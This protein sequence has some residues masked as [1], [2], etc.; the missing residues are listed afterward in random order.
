MTGTDQETKCEEGFEV[1]STV[2]DEEEMQGEEMKQNPE[3][4]TG[5][6]KDT[7]EETPAE[8]HPSEEAE[9]TSL[10][11]G[12]ENKMEEKSSENGEDAAAD[13]VE[14]TDEAGREAKSGE[15]DEPLTSAPNARAENETRA[16]EDGDGEA[17]GVKVET[18][19]ELSDERE[20]LSRE[21]APVAEAEEGPGEGVWEE[22]GGTAAETGGEAGGD[23]PSAERDD[24]EDGADE[25]VQT[26]DGEEEKP[27]EKDEEKQSDGNEMGDKGEER[28]GEDNETKTDSG[29]GGNENQQNDAAEGETDQSQKTNEG[30]DSQWVKDGNEDE[31]K[32][33]TDVGEKTSEM[34]GEVARTEADESRAE[35]PE[36]GEDSSGKCEKEE[37]GGIVSEELGKNTDADSAK[38]MKNPEGRSVEPKDEAANTE[39]QE[40][41][42]EAPGEEK[43]NG[44]IDAENGEISSR[45]ESV[46]QKDAEEAETE[47]QGG[48]QTAKNTRDERKTDEVTE[49]ERA[50]ATDLTAEPGDGTKRHTAEQMDPTPHAGSAKSDAKDEESNEDGPETE[51][52]EAKSCNFPEEVGEILIKEVRTEVTSEQASAAVPPSSSA[53]TFDIFVDT[54]ALEDRSLSAVADLAAARGESGETQASKASEDGTSVVLN[55]RA[56]FPDREER[57]AVH[58]EITEIVDAGENVDLVSN[59]VTTHQVAKFFETFVE[60]LDDLKDTLDEESQRDRY[61]EPL[62][63]EKTVD[64]GGREQTKEEASEGEHEGNVSKTS[65]ACENDQS[66]DKDQ[67]QEETEV[68]DLMLEDEPSDKELTKELPARSEGSR[69][70]L[71]NDEGREGSVQMNTEQDRVST[72]EVKDTPESHRPISRGSPEHQPEQDHP[73]L[74]D[75]PT[76]VLEFRAPSE[77]DQHSQHSTQPGEP[78]KL[79][80]NQPVKAEE[81]WG[82]SERVMEAPVMWERTPEEPVES[83]PEPRDTSASRETTDLQLIP[84]LLHSKD[85]LSVSSLQDTHFPHSSYPMLAAARTQNGQ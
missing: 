49:E 81:T 51:T 23:A 6:S 77:A 82:A 85:R 68:M 34:C 80:G 76:P 37:E 38:D 55:P 32:E 5:D 9:N 22:S 13:D 21:E 47:A 33:A 26:R 60:P 59:W 73:D 70:P 17:G 62:R 20:A 8:N 7:A 75:K 10:P 1:Q 31:E 48:V 57:P 39:G 30:E 41:A 18:K 28:R 35:Q 45:T 52:K 72:P 67:A 53:Q 43:E 65:E 12:P 19:V 16:V 79:D 44:E 25:S 40:T 2:R 83:G 71:Q 4:N 3:E 54:S 64:V 78:S 61:A 74:N 36:A 58:P 14:Q 56:P 15:E 63:S 46:A 84:D 66:E 50:E 27:E 11:S 24:R 69:T 42:R 29:G